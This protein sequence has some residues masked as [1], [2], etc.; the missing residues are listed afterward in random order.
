MTTILKHYVVPVMSPQTHTSG[1][2]LEGDKSILH[3]IFRKGLF[4]PAKSMQDS[5]NKFAFVHFHVL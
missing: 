3:T 4:L 2:I 1:L 5:P